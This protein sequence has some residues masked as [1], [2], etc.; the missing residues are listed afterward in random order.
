MS[1]N[2]W[3]DGA[4]KGNPGPGGWGVY[5]LYEGESAVEKMG[6]TA[7]TTNNVMEL[8]AMTNALKLALE[9]GKAVT[10]HVDSQYVQKGMTE[11]ITGWKRNGWRTAKK[12]PVKN[13]Q[14]WIALDAAHT[15]AKHLVTIAWVKGHSGD[16][17]NDAADL[18]ANQGCAPY[19]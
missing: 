15:A 17:G 12:E 7:M 6:G 14:E 11:W 2:I 19:L 16:A 10:I 5:G 13:Q 4:C 9:K 18:L 3:C 8:T 1:N